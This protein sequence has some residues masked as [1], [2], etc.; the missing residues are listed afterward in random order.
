MRFNLVRYFSLTSAAIIGIAVIFFGYVLQT[1]ETASMNDRV[2]QDNVEVAKALADAVWPRFGD[3][4]K[5]TPNLEP[6]AVVAHPQTAAID[7]S[8]R[9]LTRALRTTKV[10][11]F[12][13]NG[14]T[15]YSSNP[16]EIGKDKSQGLGFRQ[17]MDEMRAVSALTFRDTFNAYEGVVSDRS[18][19]ESYV[20][21]T[22]RDGGI[23]AVFEVYADVTGFVADIREHTMELVIVLFVMFVFL[24]AALFLVVQRAA[25]QMRRMAE[26]QQRAERELVQF[27][28][29]ESLGGLAGGIA[30]NL[31]NL[32]QPIVALSH[33]LTASLPAETP[34]RECADTIFTAGTR[35]SDL[36]RRLM[37]FG[38]QDAMELADVD[39]AV[40]VSD[41]VKMARP[42]LPANARMD[43]DIDADAGVVAADATQL[44]TVVMNLISNAAHALEGRQGDISVSVG[45]VSLAP[46]EARTR[47]LDFV[48]AVRIAVTDTGT[49]MDARTAERVFDPFF[50]T[51][52]QGKGTGLGLSTAYGIVVKHGGSIS[53]ES[54]LGE[55][56]TFEV[57][58]PVASHGTAP[59]G[60]VGNR[61]AAEEV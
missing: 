22:G 3:F 8:L 29:L 49:G 30:H 12:L 2:E 31:N 35:A 58:L 32:M 25:Q 15:A 36:V 18:I 7:A 42:S 43:I 11:I 9:K 14:L 34:E 1:R 28:K 10:K 16:S 26:D 50:S 56:A 23:L 61:V 24:Y 45:Q 54:A 53:C 13:P 21:I 59:R 33:R 47:A 52:E 60:A 51:K 40:L 57:L 46:G 38:R 4:L 20:P 55:G 19:V 6:A 37:I 39:V 27:R 5:Q 41:V 44:Q 17:S 48:R